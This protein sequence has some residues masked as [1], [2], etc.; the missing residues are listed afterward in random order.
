MD[1]IA[2]LRW[3][4]RNIAAFGGDTN[5]VTI[6][7]ESAG[8]ANVTYLMT[9]PLAKGLFHRAIAESGYFGESTPA[10][11]D[12]RGLLVKSAHATGLEFGKAMGVP[13]DDA[14][15]LKTLRALTPEKLLRITNA[16][17]TTIRLD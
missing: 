15:A 17:W 10:L 2:A 9:S 12:G 5:R 13:G 6:F 1:Q 7:G 14:A 11:T 3:V 4:Q 8:A 16:Q